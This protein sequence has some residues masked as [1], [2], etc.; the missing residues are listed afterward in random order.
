MVLGNINA[1]E[2]YSKLL[3]PIL[4]TNTIFKEGITC[5]SKYAAEDSLAVKVAKPKVGDLRGPETNTIGDYESV[6]PEDD[7]ITLVYNNPFRESVAFYKEQSRVSL[8]DLGKTNLEIVLK[9]IALRHDYSA[10]ACA[11]NEFNKYGDSSAITESNIK[12][13]ILAMSAELLNKDAKPGV[14]LCSYD[15]YNTALMIGNK[16]WG[17]VDKSNLA[18][19]GEFGTWLGFKWYPTSM[20]Q[21]DSFTYKNSTGESVD[22]DIKGSAD[23]IMYDADALAIMDHVNDG[24]IY[25]NNPKGPGYSA[26]AEVVSALGVTNPVRGLVHK[27]AASV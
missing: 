25:Q 12:Q 15:V 8:Y 13:T 10:L 20:F 17:D 27:T 26:Q 4:W 3:E 19:T 5:T 6:S 2:E 11:I 9:K 22:V 7:L 23:L 24:G 16:E 21:R 18:R 1:Q 14:I